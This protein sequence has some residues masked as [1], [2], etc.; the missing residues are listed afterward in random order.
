[1]CSPERLC[2]D[3]LLVLV[4]LARSMRLSLMKAAH[5]AVS[6]AARQEIRGAGQSFAFMG[7][8]VET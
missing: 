7:A 8:I 2:P 4:A 5:A 6:S 3:F 1:M